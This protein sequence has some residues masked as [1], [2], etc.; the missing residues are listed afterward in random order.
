MI[1][2]GFLQLDGEGKIKNTSK[3]RDRRGTCCRKLRYEHYLIELDDDTDEE[4]FLN[5]YNH[6]VLH[7]IIDR[8]DEDGY[9]LDNIWHSYDRIRALSPFKLKFLK[10]LTN[11]GLGI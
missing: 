8:L 4:S 5:I 10:G 11:Y 2:L 6:E 9:S 1:E 7:A 3:I